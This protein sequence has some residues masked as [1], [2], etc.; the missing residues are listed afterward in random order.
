MKTKNIFVSICLTF[1]LLFFSCSSEPE[2]ITSQFIPKD[3]Y[4]VISFNV[5]S[6][7]EKLDFKE[8]KR[9]SLFKELE[10]GFKNS[11]PKS[12]HPL[13][14]DF[15]NSGIDIEQNVNLFMFSDGENEYTCAIFGLKDPD[16]YQDIIQ[17]L[18]KGRQ[19]SQRNNFHYF[20]NDNALLSWDDNISL[21]ISSNEYIEEENLEK[22]LDYIISLTDE[23]KLSS[24]EN[25]VLFTQGVFDIGIW[26]NGNK[27]NEKFMSDFDDFDSE[28]GLD[29]DIESIKNL[30]QYI[31]TYEFMH[32]FV[33]FN[34]GE[35]VGTAKVY[36]KEGQD[37]IKNFYNE[38]IDKQII[39]NIPFEKV[40]LAFGFSINMDN[41]S[42]MK[43]V[44]E[45]L[46]EVNDLPITKEELFK[47]FTGD[48]VG[49]LSNFDFNTM[50]PIFAIGIKIGDEEV[51]DKL[52]VS[53]GSA[54]LIKKKD[55]YLIPEGGVFMTVKNQI[56]YITMD[57]Q[58]INQISSNQLK[59]STAKKQLE[60]YCDNYPTFFLLDFKSII[61][62][63]NSEY[64]SD[65]PWIG[66]ITSIFDKFDKIII[67]SNSET[68]EGKLIF[69]ESKDNAIITL[70]KMADRSM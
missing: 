47:V 55:I 53:L 32:G 59:T 23:N 44:E 6:F 13:F 41:L 18:I 33:N 63:L 14:D 51:F 57:E 1:A 10:R 68:A 40:M 49:V 17:E 8:I 7:D 3:A 19:I 52:I 50:Q 5:K 30:F 67:T 56:L 4:L 38:K 46:K 11:T 39:A 24:V 70:L 16:K 29:D 25:Y 60:E 31:E 43:V 36:Y 9:L 61:E 35:I 2:Q 12:L 58:V 62:I 42:K 37:E 15:S 54:G 21:F 48:F 65:F 34:K 22:K 28:Y 69:T 66:M 45:A 26:A 27:L 20:I 64:S